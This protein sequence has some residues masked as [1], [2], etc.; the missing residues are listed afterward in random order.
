MIWL[1][2]F[3]VHCWVAE[4]KKKKVLQSYRHKEKTIFVSEISLFHVKYIYIY[5]F[6]QILYNQIDL[7]KK[8]TL[9]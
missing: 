6:S 8:Y 1:D 9:N 4:Q 5:F 2:V 3:K 7:K